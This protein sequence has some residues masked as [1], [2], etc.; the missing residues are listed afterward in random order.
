MITPDRMA[1]TKGPDGRPMWAFQPP[2]FSCHHPPLHLP[3]F[4]SFTVDDGGC[5]TKASNTHSQGL[6]PLHHPQL[7]LHVPINTWS[8]ALRSGAVSFW[9]CLGLP[10]NTCLCPSPDSSLC[11]TSNALSSHSTTCQRNM[12]L[13]VRSFAIINKFTRRLTSS[14]FFLGTYHSIQ[15]PQCTHPNAGQRNTR[16]L[17]HVCRRV[18]RHP[19]D[20]LSKRPNNKLIVTD[21]C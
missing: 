12:I 20:P 6:P 5:D 4:L 8:N 19:Q 3:R 16:C 7:Y 17:V 9:Q 15:N 14:Y 18:L 2:F 21:I 11:T 1:S 10:S 13:H